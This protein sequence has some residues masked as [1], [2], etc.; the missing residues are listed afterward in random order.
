M[1]P[2]GCL[3]Q[4]DQLFGV[5]ATTRTWGSLAAVAAALTAA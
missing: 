3:G 5:P 4:I 1:K 2:I